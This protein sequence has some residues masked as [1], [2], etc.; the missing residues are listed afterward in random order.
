VS[1]E[2]GETTP[3]IKAKRSDTSGQCV[4]VRRHG[5]AVEVRDSKNPEGPSLRCARAEFAAWLESAKSGDL[6]HLV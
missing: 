5:G 2:R 3:W 4:E 6:D 1:T